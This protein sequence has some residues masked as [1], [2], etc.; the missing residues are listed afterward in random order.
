M[1]PSLHMV[2]YTVA[3]HG[4]PES[5]LDNHI[6]IL[7]KTGSGKTNLAKVIAE[8]LLAQDRRVCVIDPTGVW[9][10]LR[11][12]ADGKTQSG[13]SCVIFGGQHGDLPLSGSQGEAIA[14]VVST[15]STPAIIDVRS[16]PDSEQALFFTEFANTLISSN[17]GELTLIVDEAHKFMPQAGSGAGKASSRML[18]AGNNLVSLGRGVGL[19]IILICQRPSKLH[20][21]A[22][23]QVETLV[24]MR[25]T[26]PQD[27]KAIAAWVADETSDEF[28]PVQ[29]KY[30]PV[31]DAWVWYPENEFFEL[32][33]SPL[34]ATYNSSRVQSQEIVDLPEIDVA[35]IESLLTKD[36][37]T[38]NKD[39]AKVLRSQISELKRELRKRPRNAVD[40]KE[41][42]RRIETAVDVERKRLTSEMRNF[43]SGVSEEIDRFEKKLSD[44][45]KKAVK[46]PDERPKSIA[47]QVV[48]RNGSHTS[49]PKPG[50]LTGPQQ[51]VLSALGWLSDLGIADRANRLQVA[52]LA[53]YKPK[54]GAFGN[55]IGSLRSAGFLEYPSNGT[56]ALTSKG[57]KL[58][59]VI[60]K[61][62]S[63]DDLQDAVMARLNGPQRRLLKPLIDAYPDSLSVGELARVSG[64]ESGGG[65]FNNIRG[66][67]RTLGIVEYP[68]AGRVV[69]KG[70]L[71]LD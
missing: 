51:R 8:D 42:A 26:A 66:S 18:Y 55:T 5:A 59:P 43:L 54:G 30:L 21:D 61:P 62:V 14:N 37:G 1:V 11:L 4:I 19:R 48:E 9:W 44:G 70:V 67:L 63:T 25:F 40:E 17:R 65:A 20:K 52:F 2:L 10:G 49:I 34:A 36:E 33:H 57:R 7:G 38:V 68:E 29:L 39:D 3:E 15:T 64:Y 50:D 60:E 6:A 69:A 23:T 45:R 58:V 24:S 71:F 41:I 13:H 46:K 22:L 28:D 31:G 16:L 47:P 12:M 27:H 56:V 53:G 32:I 35:A